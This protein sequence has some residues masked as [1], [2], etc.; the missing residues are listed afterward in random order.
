[1]STP[2]A[3]AS[4]LVNRDDF[5]R[6][7]DA[8]WIVP[9]TTTRV[10]TAHAYVQHLAACEVCSAIADDNTGWSITVIAEA[11]GQDPAYVRR[12]LYGQVTATLEDLLE[13]SFL[14][15]SHVLPE[16]LRSED[17]LPPEFRATS[18]WTV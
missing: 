11:M 15:G 9:P 3:P 16:T 4:L 8:S 5:G 18:V 10:R 1:M 6:R 14:I 13:W 17:L 2:F 7:P 12:K